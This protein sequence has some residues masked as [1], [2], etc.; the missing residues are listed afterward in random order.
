MGYLA[1]AVDG[2]ISTF[3]VSDHADEWDVHGLHS[4]LAALWPLVIT[5][6]ELG[7]CA[8][9]D[10]LYE[11]LMGEATAYYESREAEFGPET[12]REIERQVMLQIIDQ[13]WREHLYEMDYLQ[14]GINLRAM[15]QKDPLVEWQREGFEMFGAMMQSVATDFVTY[16]MHAQVTM[17]QPEPE[18]AVTSMSYSAPSDPSESGGSM[19]AAARLEAAANGLDPALPVEEVTQAPV[20]KSEWDK[21]PRNAPCPCG[22]GT[23]FKLCHGK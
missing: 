3:C 7:A 17:A 2:A 8:T 14:E 18:Q 1:E 4:D 19:N 12:M 5:Q 10:E 16:V 22:S 11:R 15:G 20:V 21:T 13:K 23:K 6:D 9:T